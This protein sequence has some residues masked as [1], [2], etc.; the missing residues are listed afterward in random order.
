V[1]GNGRRTAAVPLIIG[2]VAAAAVALAG[3]G[4]SAQYLIAQKYL[5]ALGQIS[6]GAQKLVFLSYEAS[7]N[8][9]SV[10]RQGAASDEVAAVGEDF[11]VLST[12][13]GRCA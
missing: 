13:T 10:R 8:L 2:A 9:A 11:A 1:A 12:R 6:T 3:Y 7:G 5:E 4:V